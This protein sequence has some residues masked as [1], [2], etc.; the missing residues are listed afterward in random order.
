MIE[1]VPSAPSLRL[2]IHVCAT[3][4]HVPVPSQH[5]SA[6]GPGEA[7]TFQIGWPHRAGR[8]SDKKFLPL[9]MMTLKYQFNIC[10]SVDIFF[11]SSISGPSCVSFSPSQMLSSDDEAHLPVFGASS[12]KDPR[13]PP[14]P[15]DSESSDDEDGLIKQKSHYLTV[16]FEWHWCNHGR[17]CDVQV[18]QISAPYLFWLLHYEFVFKIAASFHLLVCL[19]WF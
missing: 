8:P 1:P 9:E 4:L 10:V 12:S 5:G 11:G 16:D 3:T 13:H 15:H 7:T 6:T 2:R 17:G 14:P 19:V 18:W